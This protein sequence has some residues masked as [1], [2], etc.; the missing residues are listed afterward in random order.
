MLKKTVTLLMALTLGSMLVAG[1]AKQEAEKQAAEKPAAEQTEEAEAT[2]VDR[3]T[4]APIVVDKEAGE[5]LFK[6]KVKKPEHPAGDDP[7][8]LAQPN[9]IINEQ[10]GTALPAAALVAEQGVT[11]KLL[12]DAL[13]SL[14]LKAGKNLVKGQ[15][16]GTAEGDAVVVEVEIA[17]KR[18]N[19]V[20]ILK[21][22]NPDV[23]TNYVFLG[24]YDV[25]QQMGCGCLLCGRSGPGTVIANAAYTT[26]EMAP[27][28]PTAYAGLIANGAKDGDEVTIIIRAAK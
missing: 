23:K 6:A 10:S 20:D 25:Q 8:K 11:A 24:N 3:E 1:C 13:E 12:T 7:K 27:I 4:F 16:N 21:A 5:V 19:W 26:T 18:V 2:N 9:A 15:Q 22:G 17:G 14:G 28:G